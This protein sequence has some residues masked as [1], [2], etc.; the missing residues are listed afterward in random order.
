MSVWPAEND[1]V[2]EVAIMFEYPTKKK[3]PAR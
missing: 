3:Y 2:D 1:L